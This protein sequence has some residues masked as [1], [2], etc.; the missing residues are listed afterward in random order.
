ML[1]H[2]RRSHS[3]LGLG[4]DADAYRTAT[5]AASESSSSSDDSPATP[6]RARNESGEMICAALREQVRRLQQ[7]KEAMTRKYDKE[8][9]ALNESIKVLEPQEL[10]AISG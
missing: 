7:E 8:I 4:P 6:V 1:E 10:S 3:A 2:F 5:T 9:S